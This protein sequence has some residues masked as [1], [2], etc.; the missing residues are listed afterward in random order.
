MA[1]KNDMNEW[2]KT[3]M[4]ERKKNYNENDNNKTTVDVINSAQLKCCYAA[5]S[6]SQKWKPAVFMHTNMRNIWALTAYASKVIQS[7]TTN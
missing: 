2:I 1:N 5:A 7:F 4:K 6:K 3:E